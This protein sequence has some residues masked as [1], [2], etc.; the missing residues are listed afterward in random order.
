[1]RFILLLAFLMF[2]QY[3]L[4]FNWEKCT[5]SIARA[6][7]NGSSIVALIGPT[8]SATSSYISSTRE[9]SAFGEVE[10]QQKIFL[11]AN[12][13]LLKIEIAKGGGEYL[14][15]Y[16]TLMRCTEDEIK[17]FPTILKSNYTNIFGE[18][19]ESPPM[20]S[21]LKI[22]ILAASNQIECS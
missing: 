7:P 15:S 16:L 6:N 17:R 12:Y 2:P 5:K 13:D 3:T 10:D 20:D 14:T 19:L 21:F 4:A 1:M 8:L 9:C 18:Q 22:K 11:I